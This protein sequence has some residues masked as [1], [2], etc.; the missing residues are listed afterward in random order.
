MNRADVNWFLAVHGD[1]IQEAIKHFRKTGDPTF[2][3]APLERDRPGAHNVLLMS[4][5][6][7]L[8]VHVEIVVARTGSGGYAVA[9][10][11]SDAE[12]KVAEWAKRNPR[13]Q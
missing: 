13:V 9:P 6:A 1:H 4:D 8:D 2:N 12:R 7:L 11:N 10:A 3:I 5:Q